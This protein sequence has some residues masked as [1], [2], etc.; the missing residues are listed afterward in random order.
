MVCFEV[1]TRREPFP[2]KTTRYMIK[3]VGDKRERPQLPAASKPFSDVVILMK[4]C[5]QHD[6]DDRPDGFDPIVAELDKA[7]RS[8]GG[9]TR[10]GSRGSN[11]ESSNIAHDEDSINHPFNH[12][13]VTQSTA[14]RDK[15]I[16]SEASHVQNTTVEMLRGAAGT[17]TA[18]HRRRLFKALCIGSLNMLVYRVF[19][20]LG[21]C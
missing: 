15:E 20:S 1:A 18:W 16:S 8:V 13:S 10:E 3:V 9:D 7:L 11:S 14:R 5:W 12:F 21:T 17:P 6:P 2:G 4:K 19:V